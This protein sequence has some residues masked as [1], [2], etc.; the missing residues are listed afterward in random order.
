MPGG[1]RITMELTPRQLRIGIRSPQALAKAILRARIASIPPDTPRSAQRRW[2]DA[3][4]RR[5]FGDRRKEA[6]LFADYDDRTGRSKRHESAATEIAHGRHMLERFAALDR[7]QPD[8][9][10]VQAPRA[11]VEIFGHTLVLDMDLAYRTPHGWNLVSILTDDEIRRPEHL[12]L[13]AT[14]LALHWERR[15]DGGPVASVELWLLK[16]NRGS[17]TWPRAVLRRSVKDLHVRL[18]DIAR[19]A[20]GQ[21]A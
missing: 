15:P 10:I 1:A 17:L 14:A 4:I 18:D 6:T 3:S 7:E 8:P 16:G 13:Y 2:M 19:G 12:Q 9:T 11:R 5:Y 20:P 21:A